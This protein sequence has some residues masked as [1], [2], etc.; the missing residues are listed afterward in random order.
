MSFS[1][2]AQDTKLVDTFTVSCSRSSKST[3]N[4]SSHCSSIWSPWIWGAAELDKGTYPLSEV[5]P[6]SMMEHLL[7]LQEI[8]SH[9][10]TFQDQRWDN[11]LQECT[12]TRTLIVHAS[13]PYNSSS[14]SCTRAHNYTV[15]MYLGSL[16]DCRDPLPNKHWLNLPPLPF[17]LAHLFSWCTG[18]QIPACWDC[19]S[20]G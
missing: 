13:Q 8:A 17:T 5:A 1:F 6:W 16:G 20:Q 2:N 15:K 7:V 4:L 12:L 18:C 10:S 3:Q 19:L 11:D 9:M 14:Q